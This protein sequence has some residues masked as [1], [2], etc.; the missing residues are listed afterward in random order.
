MSHHL[1][2]GQGTLG[3]KQDQ[4]GVH[5]SGEHRPEGCDQPTQKAKVNII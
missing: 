2:R 4:Q 5:G 1:R 3:H